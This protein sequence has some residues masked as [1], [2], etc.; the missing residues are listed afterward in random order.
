MQKIIFD[1]TSDIDPNNNMNIK[2]LLSVFIN[3]ILRLSRNIDKVD[4]DFQFQISLK[5]CIL[6]QNSTKNILHAPSILFTIP[7]FTIFSLLSNIDYN[8]KPTSIDIN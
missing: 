8:P 6:V 4:K 1:K 7:N 3:T 2:N 5:K